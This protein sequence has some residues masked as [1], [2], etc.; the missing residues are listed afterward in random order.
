LVWERINDRWL[1]SREDVSA[2]LN[3]SNVAR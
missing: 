3:A 2:L 1:I